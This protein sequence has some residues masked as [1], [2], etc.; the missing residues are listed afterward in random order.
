MREPDYI[1][2]DDFARGLVDDCPNCEEIAF[3]GTACTACGYNTECGY[4]DRPYEMMEDREND[5]SL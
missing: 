3:D 1:T 5:R 4:D 2:G